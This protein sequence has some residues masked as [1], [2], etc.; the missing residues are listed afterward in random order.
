MKKTCVILAPKF[1]DFSIRSLMKLYTN[2]LALKIG[3][4][5]KHTPYI[6][7]F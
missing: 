7:S 4:E 1:L 3:L 5:N 6:V 2:G